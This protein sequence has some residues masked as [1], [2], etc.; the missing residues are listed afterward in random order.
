MSPLVIPVGNVL[1]K[2]R[3]IAA[4]GYASIGWPVLAVHHVVAGACTCSKG[5]TCPSPGK[6]PRAKHGVKEATI[7]EATIRRWWAQHPSANVGVAM[8]GDLFTVDVDPR[9]RGDVTLAALL[10]EHGALPDTVQAKTGG[11]GQHI[12]LR[13]A[14]GAALRGKLGDGVDIKAAGGYIVVAPSVHISGRAYA[15]IEGFDPVRGARV[16]DAPAWLQRLVEKTPHRASQGK[17]SPASA[18]PVADSPLFREGT[19]NDGLASVGGR[20]RRGGATEDAILTALREANAARCV[21][22]L[23]DDEVAAI[24]RSLSRYAPMPSAAVVVNASGV[25]ALTKESTVDQREAALRALAEGARTLDAIGRIVAR[26]TVAGHLR[27]A[28]ITAPARLVDAAFGADTSKLDP[29]SPMVFPDEGDTPWPDSIDAKTLLDDLVAA[30]RRHVVLDEHFAVVCALWIVHSHALDA[31]QHSPRL[32]IVSPTKRCGKTQLLD[33]LGCLV[34]RSLH[35]ANISTA[36]LFRVISSHKPTLLIDEADTFLGANDELRGILNSGHRRATASVMRSSGDDHEPRAFQVWSAVAIATIGVE[37]LSDTLRDRSIIVS[38][39]RRRASDHVAPLRESARRQL[40]ELRRRVARWVADHGAELHDVAPILPSLDDRAAD[41][42]SPLLAIADYAGGG[43]QAKARA[44]A[45]ATSGSRADV[46]DDGD[47]GVALLADLAGLWPEHEGATTTAKLLAGLLTLEAR[48]WSSM[49]PHDRPLTA[50]RLAELLKSFDAAPR[51]LRTPEG[52]RK[53]YL[54]ADLA[55][56]LARY[57][58]ASRDAATCSGKQ[59]Q[60][61]PCG[62]ATRDETSREGIAVIDQDSSPCR[63]VADDL[64]PPPCAPQTIAPI[65]NAA[66]PSESKRLLAMANESFWYAAQQRKRAAEARARG[67]ALEA[68]DL[69]RDAAEADEEGAILKARSAS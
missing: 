62:S 9:N 68:A 44:A 26:D 51:D 8:S 48:P 45:V 3:L 31:A 39:R 17:L 47:L 42:W 52:T 49:K 40:S 13:S 58:P 61:A 37:S 2:D 18:P 54:R 21:P 55:D 60:K 41:S 20:L 14:A 24:A 38:M 19:R 16:A 65:S 28:G 69:E 12:L 63:G 7:D 56:A 46:A 67:A 34:R 64:V 11:G 30:V 36:A 10:A 27:A 23:G 22:P 32:A 1:E 53:G 57:L 15:W 25:A 43:W 6:H 66:P 59:A 29:P 35:S 5:A 50:R 33:V 4:L